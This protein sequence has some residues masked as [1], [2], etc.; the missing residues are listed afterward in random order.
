M[1]FPKKSKWPLMLQFF[2]KYALIYVHFFLT[3]LDFGYQLK[4]LSE[5]KIIISE[6]N[7]QSVFESVPDDHSQLLAGAPV[8]QVVWF[9]NTE[10]KCVQRCK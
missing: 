2:R 10:W 7:F 3:R 4:D 8:Q 6:T 9:R 1:N 5:Q